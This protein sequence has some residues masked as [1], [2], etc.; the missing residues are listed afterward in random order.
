MISSNIINALNCCSN[1]IVFELVSKNYVK[2]W[3]HKGN[4]NITIVNDIKSKFSSLFRHKFFNIFRLIYI[5]QSTFS[6]LILINRNYK[7]MET[8][9]TE[10]FFCEHDIMYINNHMPIKAVFFFKREY[11]YLCMCMYMHSCQKWTTLLQVIL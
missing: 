2:P 3:L 1:R 8:Y 9:V 7:N 6:V 11:V 10:G 5:F 4:V